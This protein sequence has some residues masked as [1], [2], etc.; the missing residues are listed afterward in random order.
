MFW[1]LAR[2]FCGMPH[3]IDL[4]LLICGDSLDYRDLSQ[5]P[6]KGSSK[7]HQGLTRL[8]VFARHYL[9]PAFNQRLQRRDHFS[10]YQ[11]RKIWPEA[12]KM[13]IG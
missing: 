5:E 9:P 1:S 3:K 2:P 11:A 6:P 12:L 8:A 10:P 13:A 7:D 4:S